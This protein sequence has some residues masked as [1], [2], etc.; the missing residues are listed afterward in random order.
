MKRII[1]FLVLPLVFVLG[2]CN[3]AEKREIALL[4]EQLE[5]LRSE[6]DSLKIQIEQLKYP[7][8]DRYKEILSL[9]R[10][11]DLN[12]A[13]LKISELVENFPLS[14]EAKLSEKQKEII[15]AKKEEMRIE[16]ERIKALG[17]KA[18]KEHSNVTVGYNDIRAGAFSTA[19]T[20]TFDSYGDRYHY[21][22]ADRG[23]KFISA[24]ISITSKD[25]NPK[26]PAFYAYKI[27]GDKLELL[28]IFSLE[29]ARWDDY[30][31]Y[32]GNYH[33]NGNDFAKKATIS[34]KIGL[35]VSDSDASNPL[36]IV[37][38]NLNCMNR[39]TDRFSNPPVSYDRSG[40]CS[41]SLTL[42]IDDFKEDYTLVKILNK[43]KI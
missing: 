30:G 7:A 32:L 27:K 41:A 25:K 23:N 2:G 36:L 40:E 15:A 16:E 9:V 4:S 12:K 14:D 22:T 21:R 38:H 1:L 8:S 29:F 28:D 26:L 35:E 42:T 39:S 18:L 24:R 6:N 19:Q 3:G 37:C 33:D 5:G 11:N 20:F 43:S 17:F 10:S 13:S 34:F 31:S